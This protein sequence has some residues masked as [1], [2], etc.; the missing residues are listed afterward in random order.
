MAEGVMLSV[1]LHASCLHNVCRLHLVSVRVCMCLYVRARTCSVC[2]C[3]DAHTHTHTHT[4][5]ETRRGVLN[6][7]DLAGSEKVCACD[8]LYSF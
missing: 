3:C 7:I 5:R 8:I 4:H 6:L 1:V 2:M